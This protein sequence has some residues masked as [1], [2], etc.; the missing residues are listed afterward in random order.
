MRTAFKVLIAVFA[1]IVGLGAAAVAATAYFAAPFFE[2]AQEIDQMNQETEERGPGMEAE[3]MALPESVAFVQK[4]P[5][6]QTRLTDFGF[7]Y[8][9]LIYTP[10]DENTLRIDVNKESNER[11]I[12]YNCTTPDG[13]FDAYMEDD[14]A[15][16]IPAM[17]R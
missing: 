8:E 4:H 15:A 3:F 17:C 11:T 6:Y 2:M 5:D 14:L 10:G 1:V 13:G 7:D 9:F 16:R 12:T